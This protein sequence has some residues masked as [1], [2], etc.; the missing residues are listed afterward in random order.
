MGLIAL[1]DGSDSMDPR[2]VPLQSR[3]RDTTYSKQKE[4]PSSQEGVKRKKRDIMKEGVKTS[5]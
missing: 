5:E 4:N 3:P 1:K 2:K